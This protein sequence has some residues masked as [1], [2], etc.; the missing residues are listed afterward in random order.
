[1]L[2]Y[3]ISGDVRTYVH[4]SMLLDKMFTPMDKLK[5][6]IKKT[7]EQHC[8]DVTM[9]RQKK[10]FFLF[11]CNEGPF[12]TSSDIIQHCNTAQNSNLGN[13]HNIIYTYS[14][15]TLTVQPILMMH[16]H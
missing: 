11:N 9:E 8:D 2:Y 10:L 4:M 15:C 1:M 5:R 6:Q 12:R 7:N 14:T 3:K 13:K 16:T